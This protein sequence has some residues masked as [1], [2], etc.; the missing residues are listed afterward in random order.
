MPT[1]IGSQMPD[2]PIDPKCKHF[3]Y[4]RFAIK[5]EREN[6][7]ILNIIH[8]FR[9]IWRMFPNFV[10]YLQTVTVHQLAP[11][12]RL[13]RLDLRGNKQLFLRGDGLCD[14]TLLVKWAGT[15]HIKT[16]PPTENLC[17]PALEAFKGRFDNATCFNNETDLIFKVCFILSQTRGPKSQVVRLTESLNALF[18]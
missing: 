5:F 17:R 1:L 3:V 13:Q 14:C 15:R 8:N 9:S 12:C 2:G 6:F 16:I 18:T 4:P 10:F 11:L 7:N